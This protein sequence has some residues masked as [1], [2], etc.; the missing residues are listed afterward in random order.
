MEKD[1]NYSAEELEILNAYE[2]GKPEQVPNMEAELK[3]HRESAE[4]T[5][6][7]LLLHRHESATNLG[8]RVA[9]LH[10]AQKM[11]RSYIPES[12]SLSDEHISERR[13]DT[14]IDQCHVCASPMVVDTRDIPHMYK[15]VVTYIKNIAGKYCVRCNT[16]ISVFNGYEEQLDAFIARVNAGKH[17]EMLSD[18]M[19]KIGSTF[20]TENGKKWICTDIGSRTIIAIEVAPG[21]EDAWYDGPPYPVV[22]HV[23]D[24]YGFGGLYSTLQEALDL[25]KEKSS[26][27][28]LNDYTHDKSKRSV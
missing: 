6:N 23:F 4:A 17:D 1:A 10:A 27:D 2:A 19:F 25:F 13:E 7:D 14:G 9:Q 5:I 11:V 24:E 18:Q 22:E 12:V 20:Y 26:S 3:L 16:V 8:T 21:R 15:G 28:M